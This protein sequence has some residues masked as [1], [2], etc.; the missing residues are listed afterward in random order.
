MSLGRIAHNH[1]DASEI[2]IGRCGGDALD[3][4]V[5]VAL[6][7]VELDLAHR[8]PGVFDTHLR[9]R[10][11]CAK[12]RQR[13]LIEFTAA[14]GHAARGAQCGNQPGGNNHQCDQHFDHRKTS[15]YD[16]TRYRPSPLPA[17]CTHISPLQS[18]TIGGC[19]ILSAPNIARSADM[20]G[21][22]P[23]VSMNTRSTGA[24]QLRG[25]WSA[26]RSGFQPPFSRIE[27]L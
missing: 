13:A 19:A 25:A 20:C 11:V 15:V 4:K 2:W 7:A 17:I 22:A 1:F 16:R 10:V 21:G 24:G 6:R 23:G 26:S 12:A 8:R 9:A 3:D 27:N 18:D 5:M 14:I